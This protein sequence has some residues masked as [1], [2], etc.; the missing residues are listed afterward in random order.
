MNI[1]TSIHEVR[2]IS[3]EYTETHDAA[4]W[5]E[6]HF[7]DAAGMRYSVTAFVDGPIPI[8]GADLLGLMARGGS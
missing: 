7:T 6:V 8:D 3:V 2:S 5:I 4:R 1:A